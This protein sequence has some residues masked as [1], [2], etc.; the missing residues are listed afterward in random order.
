MKLEESVWNSIVAYIHILFKASVGCYVQ[1]CV[2]YSVWY[3][4]KASVS[5][6]VD[7][8]VYFSVED[9]VYNSIHTLIKYH[10]T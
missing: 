2:D 3:S 9:S 4:V 5:A 10:D 1:D 8:S 6:P 7:L